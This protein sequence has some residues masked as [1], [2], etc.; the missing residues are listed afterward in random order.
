MTTLTVPLK[1]GIHN[2]TYDERAAWGT[3]PVC[4]AEHGE[5]CSSAFGIPLGQ[6]AAGGPPEN[7]V[8]LGRL[9]AAPWRVRIEALP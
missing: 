7:G 8:H 3:C 2:L 4:R 5:R 1:V 9:Q 6:S